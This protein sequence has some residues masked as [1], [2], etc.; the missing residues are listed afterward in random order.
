MINLLW[1]TIVSTLAELAFP[2]FKDVLKS[3]L[4]TYLD[5]LTN[6]I[7]KQIEII[8]KDQSKDAHE[9]AKDA[10]E[11]AANSTDPDD[12]AK[13]QA[14]ADVWR[15]VAE[16]LKKENQDLKQKVD[17][18]ATI[19]EELIDYKAQAETWREA[20]ESL[21]KDND[22][23]KVEIITIKEQTISSFKESIKTL[24]MS[25]LFDVS[26]PDKISLKKNSPLLNPSSEEDL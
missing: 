13:Y 23:L 25:D 19:S 16:G 21:Q 8:T 22:A 26:S 14:V 15:E 2:A 1:G 10:E 4:S 6:N 12:V 5:E 18:N 3:T 24:S 9:R 20:Y 7:K 11:K 17:S